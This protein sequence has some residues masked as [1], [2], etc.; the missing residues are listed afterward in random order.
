MSNTTNNPR[1][2]FL[3]FLD[4]QMTLKAVALVLVITLALTDLLLGK[5]LWVLWILD[6]S[7]RRQCL[8]ACTE[9]HCFG[10]Y[11]SLTYPMH[12]SKFGVCHLAA[13]CKGSPAWLP[14][15]S[16]L[17]QLLVFVI[18]SFILFGSIVL[19]NKS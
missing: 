1:S 2:L 9:M 12:Q 14:D 11:C 15:G 3:Q 13:R 7:V 17:G 8:S 6:N 4:E 5:N 10:F 18:Y 16:S 19:S